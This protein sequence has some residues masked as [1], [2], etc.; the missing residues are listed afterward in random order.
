MNYLQAQ[1]RETQATARSDK[2]ELQD[3]I[4]S[5]RNDMQELL[6]L[7][8]RQN[9]P[10]LATP[11]SG[12]SVNGRGNF[13]PRSVRFEEGECSFNARGGNGP[14]LHSELPPS[15]SDE[16]EIPDLSFNHPDPITQ[17]IHLQQ[18]QGHMLMK[19]KMNFPEFDLTNPRIWIKKCEKYFQMHRIPIIQWQDYVMMSLTGKVSIWYEHYLIDQG[20]RVRWAQFAVDI[21]KRFGPKTASIEEE[22]KLLRQV[23]GVDEFTEKFEEMR[24]LMMQVYP[25]LTEQYFLNNY[26]SSLKRVVRCFVRIAQPRT[27]LEVYWFAK[28]YEEGQKAPDFYPKTTNQQRGLPF[29]SI[30]GVKSGQAENVRG[31]A[32]PKTHEWNKAKE[33]KSCWKC[34][35]PWHPGHKCKTQGHVVAIEVDKDNTHDED[36]EIEPTTEEEVGEEAEV[37]LCAVV[38]GEGMNSI[39]LQGKVGKL[40]LMILIDTGSTHSFMD[41][42]IAYQL[43]LPVQ[44]GS[45]LTVMVANG[46]KVKCEEICKG[47]QWEIQGEKFTKDLRMFRMGGCDLVLGMDWIDS[48]APIQLHTRPPSI[49]FMRD[50]RKVSLN[51][52]EKR[53]QIKAAS[54]KELAKWSKH[55]VCGFLIQ[56]CNSINDSFEANAT[57]CQ[58]TT[59]ENTD[60]RLQELLGEFQEVFQEP[61]GLPPVRGCEHEITL[62]PNAAP[63]KLAAYRYSHDQKNVI[64][65]LIEEML[66]T[67]IITPSSSPFASPV[68][69]V[70]KKDSTWRFC[71]D[72][73]DLNGITVKNRFPIPVIEDLFSELAGAKHFSKI[74]LRAGYHQVRMRAGDEYK[75]AF[76]T[77]QGLYEFRVM[78]FGLTNA[79][80]TF[81]ALMNMVFKPYLRKH[82]L[83]FFYDILIY[84][85]TVD[86]HLEHIKSVLTMMRKHNLYAKMSKCSFMQPQ[87][88]YL[89]HIITAEGLKTDLSKTEA[90]ADWPKPQNLK[91]MRGFLGLAGYYRRF[92][93]NYGTISRPLTDM[94]KKD[95]FQWS[96]EA[97][98]AFEQLKRALCTTPVLALPDFQKEFVIETDACYHGMGAMLMQEDRPIA[99]FSKAFGK[100][101]LGLSIYEKEFLSIINAVE[102]WKCYLLGRHFTIRTDHQSLR[103]LLDQKITTSIQQR[104]LMKLLGMDY[105]I[106][107]KKGVDNKG[108]DAL[109][110]K[111]EGEHSTVHA[112]T[113][114]TPRWVEQIIQS[115]ENDVWAKDQLAA[116]LVNPADFPDL[117]VVNGLLK[118]RGR[119]YIGSS[120]NLRQRLIVELHNSPVGGHSG[121][122]GTYMRLKSMFYWNGL[123]RDVIEYVRAC[124]TCQRCKD[125]HIHSPGLLQPLAIPEQAWSSISMDFIE[126]LPKS[127]NKEV[128]LVIID[129]L[130]KYGHFLALSH[131]Y[132]VEQVAEM[133]MENIYKLHGLPQ[134]IVSDR[135]RVFVSQFW[136]GVFKA[137]GVKLSMSTAYH[138][139]S[140]GQTERLNRCLETYLRCMTFQ[141]PKQWVK[142]LHLAEFWYNSNHHSSLQLTPFQALYGYQPPMLSG[143]MAEGSTNDW[144]KERATIV[145]SLKE[146]LRK[147][148]QRMKHY[149]GKQRTERELQVGDMVYLKVQP[150]KQ[151][152]LAVRT[153]IKLAS[154]FYGPYTVIERVGPVA[155]RLQMPLGTLIHP[156]FHISQLKKKVT[157]F[158]MTHPPLAVM[159]KFLLN[160][161]KLWIRD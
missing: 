44:K 135:D 34:G 40:K 160:Q 110:R 85:K 129:R 93:R 137:M 127:H 4:A 138:P 27:L 70:P 131:P 78:P 99:Y 92:V 7:N 1:I 158:N 52:M 72:Y 69:L 118:Y 153:N 17:N 91:A 43:K 112:I 73:R 81:Q 146:N 71:V 19:S 13:P 95:S 144:I 58:V 124:D 55:G 30:E 157:Q 149:A 16:D 20:G 102:K 101:H 90:V 108:A 49:S 42:K 65:G 111:M 122:Q 89:G 23:G 11:P 114:V 3:S 96:N 8:R 66:E 32:N 120:G 26:V 116:M 60:Y 133:F 22:F 56:A 53:G 2:Q 80:A 128:V 46:Q 68:L 61:K 115:Y 161:L 63:V 9:P 62:V 41:P 156:V 143:V 87:I 145:S 141:R 35:D 79:P 151:T 126:G 142:W 106:Q 28:E 75:T 36:P 18:N 117:T 67:G 86:S 57:L 48:F 150:Y 107:Y 152:S 134:D 103:F 38:G 50:G 123:K 136:K 119:W 47:F 82:V 104:G 148:Q 10:L 77:H 140:D 83:V 159:A 100:K 98:I 105:T 154:K 121:Q 94:L 139:H 113:V 45:I 51:G 132:T 88:E 5:L 64:E 59:G 31:L 25:Y 29:K 12:S 39:K 37:T 14:A 33:N 147:A 6:R 125:E 74:D 76:R 97:E 130:T 155:Y 15:E 84:S 109:S 54:K 21:C 24:S